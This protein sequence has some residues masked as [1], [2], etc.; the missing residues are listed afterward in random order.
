VVE[1]TGQPIFAKAR[2]LGPDKL[3]A[4]EVEFKSL[5]AAGIVCRSDSPWSSLLHMVPE[6]DGSWRP[7]GDYQRLNLATK[8]DRYPLPSL[9]DLS[10]KLHGCKYFLVID[11]EKSYH[12]IP[13]AVA[14]I[15]KKAITTPFRMFEY[16]YMPSG[17]KNVSQTFQRLM[18]RIFHQLSFLF[19][20]LD[21]HLI[22]S[23]TL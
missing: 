9:A 11:L 22:A 20:H 1:T 12:Q 4:A 8:L 19:S 14:D 17:L 3:R 2:W 6:K 16:L 21:D 5:E 18:D 10:N 23:R 15:P 7:C 13:M